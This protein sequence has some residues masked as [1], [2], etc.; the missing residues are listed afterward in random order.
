MT[1]RKYLEELERLGRQHDFNGMLELRGE[2]FGSLEGDFTEKEW[3]D[4]RT[5]SRWAERLVEPERA[6]EVED[7]VWARFT[8]RFAQEGKPE[9]V[10]DPDVSAPRYR[11]W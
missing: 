8:E 10:T 5:L 11:W 1:T 6:K 2:Y 7:R 3:M 4:Q 9:T